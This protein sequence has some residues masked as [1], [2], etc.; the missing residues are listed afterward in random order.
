MVTTDQLLTDICFPYAGDAFISTKD[1]ANFRFAHYTSADTAIK[2]IKRKALWMRNARVMNDY[3]E[4]IYGQKFLE[5]AW[6]AAKDFKETLKSIDDNIVSAVETVIN[7]SFHDRFRETYITS[8]IHHDV[9]SKKPESKDGRL[10]MWR[11]YGG[12]TNVAFIFHPQQFFDDDESINLFISPVLYA[13]QEEFSK[14]FERIANGF[15]EHQELLRSSRPDQIVAALVRAFHFTILSTKHRGF[16][17][18]KEWRV[19]YS[20]SLATS[21]ITESDTVT[22][23]GVP[24]IIHKITLLKSSEKHPLDTSLPTILDK[25]IIGPCQNPKIIRDALR[26]ELETAGIKDAHDRILISDIP[27]RRNS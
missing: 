13:D 12:E 18:E 11:A 19:L 2:I 22:I 24:Q 5:H 14:Q 4:I 3:S 23:G 17:E 6:E 26:A 27:F 21:P 20:P 9:S 15:K 7:N 10:S 16:V 1:D 25:I 8:L